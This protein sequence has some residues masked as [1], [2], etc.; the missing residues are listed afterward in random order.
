LS[1][2]RF[3]SLSLPGSI[4]DNLVVDCTKLQSGD[5][6]K[7][8]GW[9]MLGKLEPGLYRVSKVK[10]GIYSFV[11]PKGNKVLVRHYAKNVDGWLKSSECSDL[12]K[13][14]KIGSGIL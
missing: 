6:I 2:W 4:M 14:V 11:K 13:I 5:V 9:C 8:F 3:L 12:N 1:P 7:V 10:D